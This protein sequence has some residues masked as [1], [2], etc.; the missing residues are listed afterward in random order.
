[1]AGHDH[2]PHARGRA[3]RVSGAQSSAAENAEEDATLPAASPEA[4]ND[5]ENQEVARVVSRGGFSVGDVL[6]V[7]GSFLALHTISGSRLALQA[8]A[9][10]PPAPR[11]A[12]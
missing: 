5:F 10:L 2:Q 11:P 3:A 6:I 7:A 4:R 12:G 8:L 1:M 9:T